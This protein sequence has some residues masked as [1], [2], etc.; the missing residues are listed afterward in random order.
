MKNSLKIIA[1][2]V[3]ICVAACDPPK[4]TTATTPDSLKTDSIKKDSLKKVVADT[5]KKDTAKKK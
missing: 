4:T 2:A 3:S 5:T 1:V